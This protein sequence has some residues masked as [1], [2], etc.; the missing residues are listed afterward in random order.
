MASGCACIATDIPGARD[1]VVHTE[2]GWLV[3]PEQ[4]ELLA[5]ALQHLLDRPEQRQRL[6]RAAQARIAAHYTIE[7]EVAAHEKLYAEALGW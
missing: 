4:I 5:A 2:S 7:H 3:P 1:L 6:G